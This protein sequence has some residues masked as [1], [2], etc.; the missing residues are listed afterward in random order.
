MQIKEVS[1]FIINID[2]SN[3]EDIAS[4]Q[5]HLFSKEVIGR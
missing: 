5:S 1:R 3:I 2:D 4:S